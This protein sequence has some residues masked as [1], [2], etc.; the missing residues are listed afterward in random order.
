M[1][2]PSAVLRL[3]GPPSPETTMPSNM[4]SIMTSTSVAILSST[5]A[6]AGASVASAQNGA[7]LPSTLASP[8]VYLVPLKGQMG[9]DISMQLMKMYIEDIK[10]TMNLP[11][12]PQTCAEMQKTQIGQEYLNFLTSFEA[13]LEKGERELQAV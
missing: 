8:S 10:K 2:L 4:S 11:L 12:D 7:A 6:L 5:L 3:D 9:T 1:A 13:Q